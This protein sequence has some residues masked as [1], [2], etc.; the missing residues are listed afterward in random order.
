MK[1]EE[2]SNNSKAEEHAATNN[3]CVFLQD[4]E[5]LPIG[6]VVWRSLFVR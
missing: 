6:K 1:L 2:T 4:I 3:N 5:H